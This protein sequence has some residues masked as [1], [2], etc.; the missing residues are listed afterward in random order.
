MQHADADANGTA[1]G[2]GRQGDAARVTVGVAVG[3]G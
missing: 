2:G 3:A 1:G